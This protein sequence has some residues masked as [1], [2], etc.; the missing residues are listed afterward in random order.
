MEHNHST[1]L[2]ERNDID[3]D[4]QKTEAKLFPN[5]SSTSGF[6]GKEECLV[7]VIDDDRKTL[8]KLGVS[9]DDILLH[10]LLVGGDNINPEKGPPREYFRAIKGLFVRTLDNMD[11]QGCP[12]GDE[13]YDYRIPT[14]GFY[15]HLANTY[16]GITLS[17]LHPH[18]VKN[19]H[20]FEGK[21]TIYRLD[22]LRFAYFLN[23]PTKV[24]KVELRDL[25][26]VQTQEELKNPVNKTHLV[27]TITCIAMLCEHPKFTELLGVAKQSVDNSEYEHVSYC[28]GFL[29]KL[30]NSCENSN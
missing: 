9:Y 12:W 4:V 30:I 24:S 27:T 8:E 15:A 23:L 21:G 14:I 2:L 29:D 7:K 10:I 11:S 26:Y 22:P 28:S 20:F 16:V 3:Y 17:G 19:H 6:L 13:K 1:D 18:L 5:N 25:L